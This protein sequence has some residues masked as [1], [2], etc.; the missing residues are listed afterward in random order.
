LWNDIAINESTTDLRSGFYLNSDRAEVYIYNCT[1]YV[2]GGGAF[3]QST[4]A[5]VT[6]E[7]CLGSSEG[8][9]AFKADTAFQL[10]T[11]SVS[12]DGSLAA[13]T[14]GVEN[15]WDQPIVFR[16]LAL[17]DLHLDASPKSNVQIRAHGIDLSDDPEISFADD[18]DGDLRPAG[19]TWDIGA[20]Q[21]VP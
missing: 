7:N 2:A 4:N 5:R 12:N 3:Q 9:G 10:V 1:S 19:P 6:L 21:V 13:I 11:H 17:G 20:D 16:D 18:I 8:D 14:A 15:Q